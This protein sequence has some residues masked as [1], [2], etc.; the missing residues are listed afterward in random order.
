MLLENVRFHP[1]EENNSEDLARQLAD[2]ADVFVNDAFGAAHRAHAST[3]GVARFL[4]AVAGKLMEKEIR[5]MGRALADPERPFV[6]VLGGAKI[7]DKIGVI[8]NLFQK[9]DKLLIGGGMANTFLKARGYPTGK[10]LVEEDKVE[11]AGRLWSQGEKAGVEIYLPLDLVVADSLQASAGR[12][13]KAAE[14]AATDMIVDIGPETTALFGE[15]LET[16]RTVAWNGPMGVFENPAFAKGTQAVALAMAK[17][18][19]TTIVGGGDSVAAVEQAGL[20]EK[21][22]HISTGGGASLEF[23]EGK[24]LPGVA[25]LEDRS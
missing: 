16:A 22:T 20:A 18:A 8:E 6:A 1:G 2:L 4:P 25:S 21:I 19:G 24:E 7:S 10:S 13:V 23:L 14:V 5:I 11:E 9:V 15:I 12:V 3:A 17:V